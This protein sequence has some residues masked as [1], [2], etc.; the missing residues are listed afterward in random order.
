M[1]ISTVVKSTFARAITHHRTFV[2]NKKTNTD[3]AERQKCE[4]THN[5][6]PKHEELTPENWCLH[7]ISLLAVQ[8]YFSYVSVHTSWNVAVLGSVS[9]STQLELRAVTIHLPKPVPLW[10]TVDVGL[11]ENTTKGPSKSSRCG[12]RTH[13]LLRRGL[14]SPPACDSKCRSLLVEDLSTLARSEK[15]RPNTLTPHP[16]NPGV[17]ASEPCTEIHLPDFAC[18]PVV[19]L[20]PPNMGCNFILSTAGTATVCETKGLSP[21]ISRGTSMRVFPCA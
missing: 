5:V 19:P 10:F 18:L 14:P 17:L 8:Q 6:A 16:N 15:T 20:R 13:F 21:D 12:R 1:N 9:V 4:H 7:E 11:R 2:R 3:A